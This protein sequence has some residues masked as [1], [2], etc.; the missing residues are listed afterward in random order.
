MIKRMI[1]MLVLVGVVLGGIFGYKAFVAKMIGKFMAGMANQPQT[2]STVTAQGQDWQKSADTVGSLRA[3]NGADLALDIAGVIDQIHFKSGDEVKAGTVLLTL[4]PEDD[5]AK[6]A[7]LQAA[8][9]LAEITFQR[10]QQ[11]LKAEAISQA[12]LDAD[13]ANLRTARAQVAQQQALM[14]KKIL[15]APFD[16]RLGI[17]AVDLGQYLA[18]GGMVVTLQ[19]LDP[20]YADF[21]LPEQTLASLQVGQKVTLAVDAFP[22]RNFAGQ[23][24]AIDPKVDP[25]SRNVQVR[26]KFANPERKLV[27]GMYGKLSVDQGGAAR[28][29]TLPSTAVAFNPYGA[30]VFLVDDKGKDEKGQTMLVARQSFVTTGPSR[31]DQ[32]A[33]LEGVKEGETVVAT[34]QLKL[35]NGTRL[36]INNKITPSSDPNPAVPDR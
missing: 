32:V 25:A 36:L 31:G 33:V 26:A 5:P 14:E 34:G 6:L 18:P 20:I 15:R 4:R 8:E 28:Y 13:E 21:Y 19:Q 10:D 11:Q 16:G 7:A 2:V 17:R 9:R 29:V 22:E 30:T 3:I 23:V 27:P 24:V 12:T 35:R 1:V